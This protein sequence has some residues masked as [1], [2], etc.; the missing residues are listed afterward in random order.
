MM[1]IHGSASEIAIEVKLNAG[2]MAKID[3]RRTFDIETK[4]AAR[5]PLKCHNRGALL[6]HQT[7]ALSVRKI[8]TAAAQ[9]FM[10][11]SGDEYAPTEGAACAA[12]LGMK[13]AE[14]QTHLTPGF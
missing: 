12:A 4:T 14:L 7:G 1:I 3:D 10:K 2:K 13:M 6:R 5:F 9:Q 8:A 11:C